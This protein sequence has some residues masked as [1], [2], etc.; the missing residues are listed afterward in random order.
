MRVGVYVD[1][2]NLYY[3]G[4]PRVGAGRRDGVGSTCGLLSTA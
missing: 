1:A 3:G 4:E 2:Y